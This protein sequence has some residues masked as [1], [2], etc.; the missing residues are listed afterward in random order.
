MHD[1]STWISEKFL[2]YVKA[3]LAL[4]QEVYRNISNYKIACKRMNYNDIN[5]DDDND[6]CYDD[7][8]DYRDNED[9]KESEDNECWAEDLH[10]YCQNQSCLYH[11][12]IDQNVNMK[13]CSRCGN[14]S[15]SS[16]NCFKIHWSVHKLKCKPK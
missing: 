15:Y 16:K 10:K 11:D 1:S 7:N 13:H 9:D 3:K 6:D 5:D 8:D 14:G 4:Q 12:E 2:Q